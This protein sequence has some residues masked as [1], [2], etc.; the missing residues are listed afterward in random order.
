MKQA[1]NKQ[2]FVSWSLDIVRSK[3]NVMIIDSMIQL[4]KL[5]QLV[6]DFRLAIF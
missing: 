2:L 5:T 3:E 6:F 1:T 4:H